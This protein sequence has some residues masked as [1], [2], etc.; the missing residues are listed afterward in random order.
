VKNSKY[1]C[2]LTQHSSSRK[3]RSNH[4]IFLKAKTSIHSQTIYTQ[5]ILMIPCYVKQTTIWR[6]EWRH[7]LARTAKYSITICMWSY[8]NRTN[9]E[10]T[11]HCKKAAN[12]PVPR[13]FSVHAR[14]GIA[15]CVM[16]TYCFLCYIDERYRIGSPTK[17]TFME[18]YSAIYFINCRNENNT[19]YICWV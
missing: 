13:L 7:M 17:H 9:N 1:L 6:P 19:L 11:D 5:A 12:Q 8:V 18:L 15:T 3:K 4:N 16:I 2:T 10:S 14:G